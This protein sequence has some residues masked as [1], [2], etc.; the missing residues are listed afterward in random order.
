MVSQ[1][2][3]I[4]DSR[5][6]AFTGSNTPSNSTIGMPSSLHMDP[7]KSAVTLRLPGETF[8]SSHIT[9]LLLLFADVDHPGRLILLALS[10]SMMMWETCTEI[11]STYSVA[12]ASE[13]QALLF[14]FEGTPEVMPQIGAIVDSDEGS[15]L[16]VDLL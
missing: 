4:V 16:A 14:Q 2:A 12:G 3:S 11:C 10:H 6:I 13:S 5:R 7:S 15:A 1:L 8:T 9:G